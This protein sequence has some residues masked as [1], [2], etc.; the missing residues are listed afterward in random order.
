MPCRLDAQTAVDLRRGNGIR[1]IGKVDV[2]RPNSDERGGKRRLGN[3]DNV[4]AR[5]AA[6]HV[7]DDVVA[8]SDVRL[9]L[10][11]IG[12]EYD[13]AHIIRAEP[14]TL[15][16]DGPEKIGSGRWRIELETR[17]L[18][19]IRM[20]SPRITDAPTLSCRNSPDVHRLARKRL[21][22][23]GALE[24]HADVIVQVLRRL[25]ERGEQ[26]GSHTEDGDE[27]GPAEHERRECERQSHL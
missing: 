12:V 16:H 10:E 1:K 15:E 11:H 26:G 3:A 21:S 5:L 13:R 14:A 22:V 19:P 8:Y 18:R 20:H 17:A 25:V 9:V 4:P 2:P 27:D 23:I 24:V 6:L 7:Q